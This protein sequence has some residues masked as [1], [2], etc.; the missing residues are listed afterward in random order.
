MSGF[1]PNFKKNCPSQGGGVVHG[2]HI[3]N[4]VVKPGHL[5]PIQKL[6]M[7]AKDPSGAR[8]M[9]AFHKAEGKKLTKF[10]QKGTGF[11]T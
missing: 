5:T 10:I 11:H 6:K 1:V 9:L 3:M 8:G 7:M 2:S 4:Y